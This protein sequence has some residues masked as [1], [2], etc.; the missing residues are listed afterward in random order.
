MVSDLGPGPTRSASHGH[1]TDTQAQDLG[2]RDTLVT[3]TATPC[4]F[5]REPILGDPLIEFTRGPS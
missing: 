5:K 4:R 1:A 3:I 2:G